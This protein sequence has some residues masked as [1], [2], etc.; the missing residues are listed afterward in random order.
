MNAFERL[1]AVFEADV[2]ADDALPV[3]TKNREDETLD[4]VVLEVKNASWQWE[5]VK[6]DDKEAGSAS[7]RKSLAREK[8]AAKKASKKSADAKAA[9]FVSDEKHDN[10]VEP[11]SLQGISLRIPRGGAVHAVVG[12]IGSGKSSL[13]CGASLSH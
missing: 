2:F 12:P 11:F 8:K 7:G 13:L 10:S 3:N 6:A 9:A 5:A 1:Q 4:G